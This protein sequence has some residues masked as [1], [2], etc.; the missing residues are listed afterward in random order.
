MSKL[1]PNRPV[2]RPNATTEHTAQSPSQS[3]VGDVSIPMQIGQIYNENR[4]FTQ[5]VDQNMTPKRPPLVE[6]DDKP[7]PQRLNLARIS[8]LE[9]KLNDGYDSNDGSKIMRKMF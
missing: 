6:M 4:V 3:L 9:H 1:P 8:Q 7:S 5:S 2:N